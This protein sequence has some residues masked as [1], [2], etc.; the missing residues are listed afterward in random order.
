MGWMK[1]NT[2]LVTGFLALT[3]GCQ[4]TLSSGLGNDNAATS[5][6][7]IVALQIT[8]TS[9]PRYP[10]VI[11]TPKITVIAEQEASISIGEANK[12]FIETEVVINEGELTIG[13]TEFSIIK[14]E[15]HA[16]GKITA[17]VGQAA[18]LQT[19]GFR[20]KALVEPQSANR[21]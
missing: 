20:I 15:R 4:L 8:D 5:G 13:S 3:A 18:E 16:S 1:L 10:V 19:G 12:Q 21:E 14:G 7:Y 9:D 2:V 11:T 17:L 6:N